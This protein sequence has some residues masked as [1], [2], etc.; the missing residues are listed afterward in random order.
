MEIKRITVNGL[1]LAYV[2]QGEGPLALLLHGFPETPGMFRHLMP[3]LAKA[4]YRTV[5]PYMRG[6]APSQVPPDGSMLMRDLIADANAL[7][8]ALGGDSDA[9]IV[10]HDWGGFATWGAAAL[11]PERWSKVVVADVPPV[12]FYERRAAVP[13]QIH[14]NSHFYFFQMAIA[15]QLVPVNDFAYIDWLWDHWTGKVPGFDST[16]DREAGK[17]ALRAP[18]NLR[19][20]LGL[21]RQNFPSE[22][23]GTDAWEMGRLL[24]ELP[25]QPTLYLHGSEDP[26]VDEEIL[27]DI[28]AALPE[29][30]DGALLHGV[31]HFP[32]VEAPEEVNRRILAFLGK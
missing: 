4:G 29:G 24:A 8:E 28:V 9:I 17:D 6:F 27:A 26:V 2:E 14:K 16:E 11:A 5:A 30:S 21:Y 25:T 19:A 23:F 31:G 20:G 22:A 10:G 3:E 12:R 13:E 15:D 32:M 7:H 18:A 1:E